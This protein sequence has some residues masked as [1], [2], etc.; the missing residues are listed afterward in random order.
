MSLNLYDIEK[1]TKAADQGDNEAQEWLEEFD[2]DE[3]D[4]LDYESEE[5]N[6]TV[7]VNE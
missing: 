3:E 6:G 5:Y 1:L 7:V 4:D 2:V